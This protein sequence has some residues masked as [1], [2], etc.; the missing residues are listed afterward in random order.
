M[1]ADAQ[2]EKISRKLGGDSRESLVKQIKALVGDNL[3]IPDSYSKK[4]LQKILRDELANRKEQQAR[5]ERRKKE[6]EQQ[7]KAKAEK[8]AEFE[9]RATGLL[10]RGRTGSPYFSSREGGM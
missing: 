7:A 10:N 4:D 3:E 9:K 2:K 8:N 5:N 6:A 1:L